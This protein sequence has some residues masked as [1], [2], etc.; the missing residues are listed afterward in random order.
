MQNNNFF[1]RPITKEFFSFDCMVRYSPN[2][3]DLTFRQATLYRNVTSIEKGR[4]LK[5]N[6]H[7]D[8]GKSCSE[9]FRY[10]QFPEF[11]YVSFYH[12][13]MNYFVYGGDLDGE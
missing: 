7:L 9:I 5:I 13:D 11:M 12:P 8:D 10:D 6:Y 2:R 3:S 1:I 4:F